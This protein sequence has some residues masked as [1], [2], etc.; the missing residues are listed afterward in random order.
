MP[1]INI[2]CNTLK[3]WI[4]NDEAILIDVREFSEHQTNRIIQAKSIP[5]GELS[6]S[7][8]PPLKNKKLVLHCQHGKR[9]FNGCNKLLQENPN[10]EIYNLDGGIY[11]WN[12]C[13]FETISA[14]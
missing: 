3:Q 5:L 1:I 11:T 13:D 2:N 9:S 4:E 14:N 10:L 8:L 7:A 6:I 12:N